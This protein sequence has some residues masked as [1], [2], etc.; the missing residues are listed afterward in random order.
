M[1]CYEVII[2][3]LLQGATEFLPVSSSGHLALAHIFFGAQEP[4]LNFD[5]VLHIATM[6]ATLVFFGGDIIRYLREWCCGITNIGYRRSYGWKVGWAVIAG[7]IITGVIG[8]GLKDFAEEAAMNSLSVGIG[9]VITGVLL[10]ASKFIRDSE[11]RITAR[12]GIIVGIAQGI[13]VFPGISRSGSTILAGLLVGISKE[14]AFVFS[15]L[16]SIPAIAGA[17]LI[18]AFEIGGW[19]NFIGTLPSGWFMGGA[20]AFISGIVALALLKRLVIAS[21]WWLFGV[22]CLV[23]GAISICTTFLGV[24]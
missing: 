21:K 7:T 4:Q 1:D 11:G 5:L 2:L 16:L 22:Y 20:A 14:D 9:L 18:Q 15:F 10:I 13:A 3:G 8:M 6:L 19:D 23:I 12:D 24:W 17:S